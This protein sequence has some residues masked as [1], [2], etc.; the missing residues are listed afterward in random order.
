LSCIERVAIHLLLYR[1][2]VIELLDLGYQYIA[3]GGL[4]RVQTKPLYPIMR[5]IAPVLKE[6]TDVHL[7]GVARDTIGNEMQVL[8]EMGV[9]S[10]DSASY[11]RRAWLD[12][13]ENY[14]TE[15]GTRYIALR[16]SPVHESRSRVKKLLSEGITTIEHL[17]KKA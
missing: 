4:A 3:L 6:D 5:A 9:T 11:L 13:T 12:T 16:I 1:D 2:A 7:F 15:D 10:F 17:R 14:Y 8:R